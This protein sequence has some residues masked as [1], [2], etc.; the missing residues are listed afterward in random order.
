MGHEYPSTGASFIGA[1]LAY[2]KQ[3]RLRQ[4]EDHSYVLDTATAGLGL[5]SQRAAVGLVSAVAPHSASNFLSFE[6]QSEELS[7]L[8]VFTF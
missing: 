4:R 6:R 3:M 8:L 1:H 7:L 2:V 5:M